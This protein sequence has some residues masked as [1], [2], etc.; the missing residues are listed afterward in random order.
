MRNNYT[1]V[2][3]RKTFELEDPAAIEELTLIMDYDDAFVAFING[4]EIARSNNAPDGAVDYESTSTSNHEAGDDLDRFN[5]SMDK[6]RAGANVLA[7]LG[8]NGNLSSS[9]FSL[10]P[11]L[12]S[13]L[14]GA[15]AGPTGGCGDS[16]LSL[17]HI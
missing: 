3:I 10:I 13:T 16:I 5:I 15:V 8:I 11:V 2:F 17:I 7:V 12:T 4:E 6:I 14:A 9:D 1:T